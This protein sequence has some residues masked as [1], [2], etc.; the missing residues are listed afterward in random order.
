MRVT[1]YRTD[2]RDSIP[3]RGKIPFLTTIPK[4]D[5]GPREHFMQLGTGG[6][7]L[8]CC[9]QV[10]NSWRVFFI[11]LHNLMGCRLSKEKDNFPYSLNYH[12]ETTLSCDEVNL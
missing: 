10:K 4:A 9:A 12:L 7:L 2:D 6:H 8:S 1:T 3:G 5:L 11:S